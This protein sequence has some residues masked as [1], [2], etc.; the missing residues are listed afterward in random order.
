M[1]YLLPIIIFLLPKHTCKDA[2]HSVAYINKTGNNI[3]VHLQDTEWLK[4]EI[5]TDVTK[6]QSIEL[7]YKYPYLLTLERYS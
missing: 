3:N 7:M 2:A 1:P 6:M 4:C 5:T